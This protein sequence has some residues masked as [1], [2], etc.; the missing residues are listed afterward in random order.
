MF[1]YIKTFKDSILAGAKEELLSKINSGELKLKDRAVWRIRVQQA[2]TIK[3]V[4]HLLKET[5]EEHKT[6]DGQAIPYTSGE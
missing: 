5:A 1:N 2:K 3:E 6:N 4:M